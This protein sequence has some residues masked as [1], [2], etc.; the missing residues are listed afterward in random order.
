MIQSILQ[1][2]G[3]SLF[4]AKTLRRYSSSV[5]ISSA[6]K[7]AA[8]EW[9]ELLRNDKLVDETSNYLKFASIVL[10]KILGYPILQTEYET[11]NVEFLFS[12][13]T[14]RKIVCFEAKGTSTK[15]LFAIQYREKKEHET[16]IKQTWDYM[17]KNALR[18]GICT[19]YKHFV[20]I[21]RNKGYSRYHFFDFETINH[22]DDR[23]REFVLVFS[24]NS[25][26]DEP[27]LD[28]LYNDSV[29]EEREFT[30]EFYKLYHETRLMLIKEF[31]E[32]GE[33]DR[34]NIVKY[35]QLFLNR[36]IFVFFAED[37]EKLPNKL[38][39][40]SLTSIL[41]HFLISDDTKTASTVILSLFERL[42]KGAH[43][44][45]E[46]FGFNGGL[47]KER[48]PDNIFFKDFRPESFFKELLLHSKLKR[49]V[50]VNEKLHALISQFQ[51]LNPIIK[52]LL[53][54]ASF[55]FKTEL[56]VDILGHIFEHSLV[57]L[58]ELKS[59]EVSRRRKE[60]I[61][62]TPEFVTDYVCR[63]A[64]VGYLTNANAT[65]VTELLAEYVDDLES[66]EEHFKSLKILD[67]ACGSGAFLLKA[68][69]VLLEIHKGILSIKESRGAF[70]AKTRKKKDNSTQMMLDKWQEEAMAAEIIENNIYGVD[71]N[72]GSVEITRLSLFLRISSRNRKLI[73][74][75]KNIKQGNSLIEDAS[76]AG[77]SAFKWDTEFKDIMRRGGFNIVIGNPPYVR[78]MQTVAIKP[79]LEKHYVTYAG[80]ADLYVY[81]FEKGISL[82]KDEGLF[83]IIVSSKFTK[84]KYA[85]NL[86]NY[87]LSYNIMTFIDFG[88]MPVFEDASTYPCIITIRKSKPSGK[89]RAYTVDSLNFASLDDYLEGK[90][91]TVDSFQ[92]NSD[93]W[94]F[95]DVGVRHLLSKIQDRGQPLDAIVRSD[96]FF[97]GITTGFNEA[98]VITESQRR[99][100]IEKDSKSAE[101][102]FPYLSGKE[103]KRYRL[104]WEG[105]YIIFVR[106]G[107]DISRYPVVLNHLE[108][109]RQQLTPKGENKSG[110]R[111][112]RKPGNYK[113]YEIQDSTDYWRIFLEE[114]IIF[115]HFNK[116]SNFTFTPGGFFPNNKAYVI[117]NSDRF[118]LALLNS[119]LMNFYL[120]SI[121]PFV[122]GE[123][124][125]YMPQYVEKFPIA[126]NRKH[127]KE[128]S[129]SVEK[130]ISAS[131]QIFEIKRKVHS[132]IMDNLHVRIT[133]K[134]D[135]FQRLSFGEFLNEIGKQK[136]HLTLKEQDDWE[137]YLTPHSEKI[138]RL[139]EEIQK[140][141][142]EVDR[143]VFESYELSES[144]IQIIEDDLRSSEVRSSR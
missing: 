110:E 48:I 54:M 18:Y 50:S 76:F 104:E 120:K 29:E 66:L 130:I 131:K 59:G 135:D 118:L 137:R 99:D 86:R 24:K 31:Q 13:A 134:L 113:W 94:Y 136:K 52:N 69:D 111:G 27:T 38:F 19:N 90:E 12:D 5:S 68:V 109:Y 70:A 44:P 144:E 32:N 26:I 119:K 6:Q 7:N 97:R 72:E 56:R 43:S 138:N 114:G 126:K 40:N 64:I 106:R 133:T 15:D 128:I 51:N 108:K 36:L 91:K 93:G 61:F 28:L 88:D 100:L 125:E 34:P 123:Y 8:K 41:N 103:I 46:I 2:D 121:C 39:E 101:V 96:Q 22:S 107:I 139:S 132:R 142:S 105:N 53:L 62:Y 115:P 45:I 63:T 14:G 75:S 37:T 42:D 78:S 89:I 92:R 84:A 87:L 60:G 58:E 11:G 80:D 17:G 25:I 129:D 95:E 73:D 57:D 117:A 71:V 49:Q 82:L 79:Y 21:D 20:L 1:G 47:F 143:L 67:P 55:D 74:L 35:A 33:I 30:E 85:M 98:F 65:N 124:Y 83:S 3:H 9:L 77:S 112:G 140:L 122:R 10:E 81:F 141:D 127:S 16:P 116:Y 102:I 4:N 23:L